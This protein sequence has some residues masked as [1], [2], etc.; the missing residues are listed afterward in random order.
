MGWDKSA[1]REFVKRAKLSEDKAW[2]HPLATRCVREGLLAREFTRVVTGQ[3][4]ETMR[5]DDV[6]ALWLDMRALSGLDDE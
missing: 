2:T 5:S 3:A 1:V 4:L 6:A